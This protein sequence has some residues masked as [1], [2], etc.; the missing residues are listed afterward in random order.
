MG[1][2]AVT[3]SLS[4]GSHRVKGERAA[5][6]AAA[7]AKPWF[8]NVLRGC[9]EALQ[10]DWLVAVLVIGVVFNIAA[11]W[12]ALLT[13]E[14]APPHTGANYA[15][16][17]VFTG[18]ALTSASVLSV[19]VL[20]LQR[21]ALLA[22]RRTIAA[23]PDIVPVSRAIS[24]C[25]EADSDPGRNRQAPQSAFDD[26]A[27]RPNGLCDAAVRSPAVDGSLPGA[28]DLACRIKDEPATE[29]PDEAAPSWIG[30]VH[31]ER[32]QALGQLAAGV[33]HDFN[34]LL[35]TV[36]GTASLIAHHA[37]DAVANRRY[38]GML[39]DATARGQSITR[40]LLGFA[41]QEEVRP[42]PLE[43]RSVLHELQQIASHTLGSKIAVRVETTCPLPHLMADKGQLETA[44]VNLAVNARDAM[45]DGGTL[46]F[47]ADLAVVAHGTFHQAVRDPGIY[48]KLSVSDTGA[49]IDGPVLERVLEP[50]FTTKP[51]GQGTGLGLPMAR[52]F[53][54][55]SGGGLAIDSS[56]GRGTVISLWLPVAEVAEP[57]SVAAAGETPKR[58]LL[59]EDDPMVSET[60]AAVL[61]DAGYDVVLARTGAEAMAVLRTASRVD[62][63]VT[64]LSIRELGGLALID[65]AHRYRPG[66]P[67][68]LLTACPDMDAALAMKGAFSG[69]FSLLRK[70]IGA[71]HLVARIEALIAAAA[72]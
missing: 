19:F 15:W 39:L 64:D 31:A 70:P 62:A 26:A 69:T 30:A 55:Q 3:E 25:I 21:R 58:V 13:G 57:D 45:P 38:A 20:V 37:D 14:S 17:H 7:G 65:E 35:I 71:M 12:Q 51:P 11:P 54:E 9:F 28:T 59:A 50:F 18:V 32:M 23:S 10:L 66:L 33:A 4:L 49:G 63:L 2:S 29:D 22:D 60:L 42:E 41:R 56:P 72:G 52:A 34:N 40:R 36:H 6:Q 43:P 61:D 1:L 46:T 27:E 47:A 8:R 44:L 24:P 16:I 67:A 68:V 48:I 5:L 53:A